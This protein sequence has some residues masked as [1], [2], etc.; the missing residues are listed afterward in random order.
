MEDHGFNRNQKW[1]RAYRSALSAPHTPTQFSE[2]RSVVVNS[3]AI[4]EWVTAASPTRRR[5]KTMSEKWK[6]RGIK[7]AKTVKRGAEATAN[8]IHQVTNAVTRNEGRMAD[9]VQAATHTVGVGLNKAGR[10]LSEVGRQA[11][12]TLHGNANRS[13]DV[14]Q[15]LITGTGQAGAVRK[16]AGL[17]GWAVTKLVAH[18]GGL[19]ADAAFV[20]G[21]VAASTGGLAKKSAP[22]FGGAVGGAVR[23]A[24]EVTSNAVDA[25]VL[26]ASSIEDMR[27]ELRSLGKM[28]IERS[29]KLQRAIQSAKSSRSKEALLD[30]LVVGGITL[31]QAARNPTGVPDEVEK[32][33]KLAYP[34]LAQSESFSEAVNRMSGDQL[35]GLASGVKGKLFEFELV[36]HLNHGG[37][38]D[39]FHAA[40]AQSTTQ[41]GWDI[42]VLDDHGHISEVLQAKATDSVQ[43]VKEALAHYPGI[44][45]TTTTEV[46]GQL[47]ALGLGQDIH[48]SGISEALLQAK[49]DAAMHGG[50]AFDA[51]NLWPSFVGLAVIALS[52]FMNKEATLR[53]KGAKFGSRSAKAGASSAVGKA[54]MVATQTWWLGLIAGVGS[55]WLDN[56]GQGKREQYEVLKTALNV[57][58]K[59]QLSLSN[60]A[61]S[62][63][64]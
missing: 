57:M 26:P 61:T 29:G 48:N 32:A 35:V 16:G 10:G 63:R 15:N 34:G 3:S 43:Y 58:K 22:A 56:F 33:F 49:V 25:A 46:H 27:A 28:E 21:K 18:A 54:T 17:L 62:Y 53:E 41:P 45:V 64:N 44:D 30:L 42:R 14:V 23:A 31:A 47:V 60:G 39:G 2:P 5:V 12:K 51:S 24:A 36:D 9:G 52:V 55:R 38:P 7:T 1:P 20:I 40:L 11:S 59:K 13:A 19:T 8:S 4:A 37:L 50:S 6:E